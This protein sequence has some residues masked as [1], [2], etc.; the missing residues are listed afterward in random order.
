MCEREQDRESVRERERKRDRG[1]K[2]KVGKTQYNFCI[3]RLFRLSSLCRT[4]VA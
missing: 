3:S 4:V 1:G 2:D